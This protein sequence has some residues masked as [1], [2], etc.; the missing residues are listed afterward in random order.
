MINKVKRKIFGVLPQFLKDILISWK[1]KL[2]FL[3]TNTE[4]SIRINNYIYGDI[5]LRLNPTYEIEKTLMYQHEYDIKTTSQFQRLI[6]SGDV[7]FDIGANMGSMTIPMAQCLGKAGRIFAIEPGSLLVERLKKNIEL[8]PS[9]NSLVRIVEI[10]LSN[11][12]GKLDWLLDTVNHGNA[13]LVDAGNGDTEVKVSTL[14]EQA[15][16]LEGGLK[17]IDFIKLDV[18]GMELEVLQGANSVLQNWRPTI[19]F[20]TWVSDDSESKIP[21]VLSLLESYGYN[22]YEPDTPLR[23]LNEVNYEFGFMPAHYPKLPSNTLAVHPSRR[24][25]LD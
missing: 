15:N 25:L 2:T 13:Y 3:T 23:R 9:L 12:P 18:E 7:C 10:G 17:K 4:H 16:M 20:E 21:K 5:N 6:K 14:D 8:N 1:P 24:Y 11:K 19:L 22:F